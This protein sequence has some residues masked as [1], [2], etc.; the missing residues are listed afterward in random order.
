[1]ILV[2]RLLLLRILLPY[3]C[4]EAIVMKQFQDGCVV[5]IFRE[6]FDDGPTVYARSPG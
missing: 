1:M 3:H 6:L 4:M 2:M 5:C